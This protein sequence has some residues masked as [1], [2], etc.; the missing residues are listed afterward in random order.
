MILKNGNK[1]LIHNADIIQ[2]D[3][4]YVNP[5]DYSGSG[6]VFYDRVSNNPINVLGS[7]V[8]NGNSFTFT[9]NVNYLRIDEVQFPFT[10][11][12]NGYAEDFTYSMWF[13][14]TSTNIYQ[15]PFRIFGTSGGNFDMDIN[16]TD[17][18]SVRRTLW[19]Y[20]NSGGGNYSSMP[21]GTF[22]GGDGTNSDFIQT[23]PKFIHYT[24]R[25]R[26]NTDVTHFINGVA[27]TGAPN[28]AGHLT[29]PIYGGAIYIGL[30]NFNGSIGSVYGYSTSL[31]DEQILYNYNVGLNHNMKMILK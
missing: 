13:K 31:T 7:P 10:Y 5:F 14:V 25:R 30:S 4:F 26:F 17:S 21:I 19:M 18:G 3:L 11:G 12:D 24:Y 2:P 23:V 6:S 9:A 22:P 1:V 29:T 15:Y 20:I 16:D 8:W 27:M 28:D